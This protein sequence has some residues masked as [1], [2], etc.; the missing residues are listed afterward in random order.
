MIERLDLTAEMRRMADEPDFD[1][2]PAYVRHL[3]MDGA[4]RIEALETAA[5]KLMADMDGWIARYTN[6]AEAYSQSKRG[7][8]L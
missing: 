3:L 7:G 8:Y 5:A 2:H 4:A 6:L 1:G